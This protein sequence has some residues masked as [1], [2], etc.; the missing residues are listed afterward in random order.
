[1]GAAACANAGSAAGL[2]SASQATHAKTTILGDFGGES[3]AAS[4]ARPPTCKK[5]QPDARK[6]LQGG[7]LGV[8]GALGGARAA[9]T[10]NFY[11]QRPFTD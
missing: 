3:T 11:F 7:A 1:M 6:T 4:L 8:C 10:R 9:D 2:G 5:F